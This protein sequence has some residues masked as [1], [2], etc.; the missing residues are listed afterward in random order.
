MLCQGLI[1][2]CNET[3][4]AGSIQAIVAAAITGNVANHI[5]TI[6]CSPH[7]INSLLPSI[8]DTPIV[9]KAITQSSIQ[10]PPTCL[11]S[12]LSILKTV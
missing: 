11:E 8:P 7:T 5:E 10:S 6:P 3:I 12:E 1:E 9:S 2:R 4:Q